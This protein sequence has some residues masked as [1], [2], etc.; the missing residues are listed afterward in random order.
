M[1]SNVVVIGMMVRIWVAIQNW[2]K[3]RFLNYY[4]LSKHGSFNH[5]KGHLW[6]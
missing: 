5:K 1:Y 3:F 2:P 4:D 6:Y